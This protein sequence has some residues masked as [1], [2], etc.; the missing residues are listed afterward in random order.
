M[1]RPI[2]SIAGTGRGLPEAVMTNFDFAKIGIE[3]TDE[4]ITERTGIKQRHIARNGESTTSMAA[5][6]ARKAMHRAGVSAG[7]IDA[8][9]LSTATPDRLLPATAVDLQAELGATRAA[10][11][12]IGAA[13]AGFIFAV[14]VAEGMIATGTAET[15][16][17]V[18][19]WTYAGTGWRT[20]ADAALALAAADAARLR[21]PAAADPAA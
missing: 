9:V 13:C 21:R 16:L 6:A 15:V 4:W 18:G 12:D 17:V 1:K 14:T 20:T 3:T 19:S 2:A 10:A 8:I 11:F 5:S 7:E